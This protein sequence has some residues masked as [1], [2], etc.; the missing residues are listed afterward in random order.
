[1]ARRLN[2]VRVSSIDTMLPFSGGCDS[3][4]VLWNWL[5]ENPGKK[6]LVYH[7]VLKNFEG[8]QD[9]E[10]N[11]CHRIL[12]WMRAQGLTNFEY[13]EMGFDYGTLRKI[14]FDM[15]IW[16]LWD[17]IILRA[18][19]NANIKNILCPYIK[20]NHQAEMLTGRHITRVAVT[21]LISKR[22][23]NYLMPI[24]NMDKEA[25][26]NALH[27][28]LRKMVWYCRRPV[29]GGDPCH[30]CFTCVAVDRAI[31]KNKTLIET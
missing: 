12:D 1:M 10:L 9:L 7:V 11:A 18:K 27:P 6:L 16:A 24:M 22:P 30:K 5:R 3:T 25:I 2:N 19:K 31:A 8:R 20:T 28:D 23:L 21:K 4:L 17:G 14:I 15:E 29:N 13:E 26:L